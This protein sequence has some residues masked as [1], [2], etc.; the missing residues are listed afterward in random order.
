[1]KKV[2]AKNIALMS[3]LALLSL[4]IASCGSQDPADYNNKLMAVI[5]EHTKSMKDMNTAMMSQDYTKAETV[6]KEW[7]G[8]LAQSIAEVDKIKPLSDDEGLRA[9]IAEGLKG[10]K[11][12]MDEDYKQLIALRIQEKNGNNAVAPQVD[13]L[14]EQVNKDFEAI[15]AKINQ[16]GTAFENK[17]SKGR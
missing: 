10:Y 12:L 6:R 11:K 3:L 15:G 16:A 2:T 8:K 1:M 4:F 9:A 7:S 13:A 17:Y 5:N 14:L